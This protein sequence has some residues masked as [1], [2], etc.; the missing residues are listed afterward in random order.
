[1]GDPNS[2]AWL[3][4]EKD[5]ADDKRSWEAIQQDTFRYRGLQG[6]IFA[7]ATASYPSL[8]LAFNSG[9]KSGLGL[10][11]GT[12]SKRCDVVLPRLRYI[13]QRYCYLTFDAER[14]WILRDFSTHGSIVKYDDKGGE[15][16]C[17]FTWILGSHGVPKETGHIAIGIQG[18]SFQIK[19]S[20]HDECPD[21]YNANVDRF[22]QEADEVNVNGLGVESPTPRG[23]HT[24]S[25]GPIRLKQNTL[26]KGT[27]AVVRRFW[28]V[29]N[30]VEFGIRSLEIRESSTETCG[31]GRSIL[32]TKSHTSVQRPIPLARLFH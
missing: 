10:I 3:F 31:R 22:L 29:S 17:H 28:D 21:L 32:C 12:D 9:L 8:H 15:L 18:I 14:R 23:A 30:G 24:P 26:G 16:R 11:F 27:Y 4:P 5:E 1:M 25:Q 7:A 2:I 6:R 20:P 19:V 13:S